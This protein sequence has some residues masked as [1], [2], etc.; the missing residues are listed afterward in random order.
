MSRIGDISVYLKR[1]DA[2]LLD[3]CW[4]IDKIPDEITTVVD[5]GCA[6]GNLKNMIDYLMPRRFRYIGID[7]SAE[8]RRLC[9]EKNIE[10]YE[11]LDH[12]P[13]DIDPNRTILVLN[14]VIHEIWTYLPVLQVCA[15]FDKIAL[16]EFKYIAIRDMNLGEPRYE[17]VDDIVKTFERSPY[18]DRWRY[19]SKHTLANIH[20]CIKEFLLKYWYTEN[21]ERER[22]EQYLWDI[23]SVVVDFIE[24]HTVYENHFFIPYVREKVLKD[25]G[26]VNDEYT[27]IKVLLEHVGV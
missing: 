14:S 1:M 5:F 10:V 23:P 17:D 27:H 2:S 16:R 3:K 11:D 22:D 7:N 26:I 6:A 21:W 4:W 9:Q 8:M 20:V 25:F 12:L 18:A 24:Y 19:V 15:L 13:N